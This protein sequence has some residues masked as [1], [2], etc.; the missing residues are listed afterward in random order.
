[1]ANAKPNT[2]ILGVF[3]NGETLMPLNLGGFNGETPADLPMILFL[4][5]VCHLARGLIISPLAFTSN[6]SINILFKHNI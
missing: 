1:M 3:F 2:G 4:A 6:A 5:C